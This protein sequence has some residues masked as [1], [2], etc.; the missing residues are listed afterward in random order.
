MAS[1]VVFLALQ[2]FSLSLALPAS[3][4]KAATRSRIPLAMVVPL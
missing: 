3:V 1:A 2:N 4:Y